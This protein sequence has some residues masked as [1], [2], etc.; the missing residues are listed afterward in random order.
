M[1]MQE[2]VDLPPILTLI[3]LALMSVVFGFLGT[4][5]AVPLLAAV[6]TAVKL[7]YVEDVVG[8]QVETVLD[9]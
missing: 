3:G 2:G 9:R 6:M 1:V 7:L 8:D 4:L 5:V